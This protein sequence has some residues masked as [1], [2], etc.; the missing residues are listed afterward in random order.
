MFTVVLGDFF[1]GLEWMFQ[2][3]NKSQEVGVKFVG[4]GGGSRMLECLI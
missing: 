4:V 2:P 1:L 3:T